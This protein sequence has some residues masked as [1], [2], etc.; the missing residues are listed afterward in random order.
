MKASMDA[1][2]DA[3]ATSQHPSSD[4][5]SQRCIAPLQHVRIT[6]LRQERVDDQPLLPMQR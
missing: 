4:R 5:D 3:N 1:M 6:N 2:P